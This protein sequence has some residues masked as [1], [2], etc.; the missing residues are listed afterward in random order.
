MIG[1]AKCVY[2]N[3]VMP[4]PFCNL[5]REVDDI[6]GV[7]QI[8]LISIIINNINFR[9]FF[10]EYQQ[11]TPECHDTSSRNSSIDSI[12]C[13]VYKKNNS[14]KKFYPIEYLNVRLAT[15]SRQSLSTYSRGIL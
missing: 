1:I 3:N 14:L 15:C 4:R 11:Q 10:T 5:V 13:Y 8:I 6:R 9:T 2:N 7:A 12:N